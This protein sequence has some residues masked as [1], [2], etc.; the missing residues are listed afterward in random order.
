L[1]LKAAGSDP[2]ARRRA[3]VTVN[4]LI[5]NAKAL[6]GKK[7]LPF[8]EQRLE[9]S[10]PL[11]FDEV[12]MEKSP[13]LRYVSRVDP[14]AI[15]AKAKRELGKQDTEAFKVML[16]SLVCGL[17]RSEIDHLLW[18]SFDF[19]K[20][21]LRIESTEYH[22]LKS[23]DSAGEIDLD[24]DTIALFRGYRAQNP[25]SIFVIESPNQPRSE[26]KA[27]TY[28]CNS[29]F[30]R[31]IVWLREQGVEAAKPIHTMRKEIGSI[32][33]SEHGIFEASRYLRHSDIRITSAFYADKK[34]TVT[35]KAFEGLL[36][37]S[38]KVIDAR[39]LKQDR[40]EQQ[41]TAK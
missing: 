22:E 10:R 21:V 2:L 8:L 31:L 34:K 35:P 12:T 20:G 41:R 40:D 38:D 25:E 17:R 27:R 7:L 15:L 37:A 4:S 32:I 23:E 24:A 28:R 13:S 14:Y 1:G 26:L 16:L 3:I 11:P 5:R 39:D 33:A 29:T 36:G 19:T 9:L 18:R 6:L 30:T